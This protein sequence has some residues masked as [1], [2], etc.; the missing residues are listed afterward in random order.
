M[1]VLRRIGQ[2]HVHHHNN[3]II[4]KIF[5]MGPLV[6]VLKN[7]PMRSGGAQYILKLYFVCT[8]K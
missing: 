5:H 6:T 1:A 3:W 4:L 7:R 8:L 2:G